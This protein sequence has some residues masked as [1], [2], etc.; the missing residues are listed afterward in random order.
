MQTDYT[1]VTEVPGGKASAE[2]VQ[3]LYSRYHFAAPY[4]QDKDVLEVACGGGQGLGYLVQK[5][6]WAVGG[7]YTQGLLLKAQEH[8]K[9]EIPF[10]RLDAH[11]LPFKNQSFDVVIFFEAI[12]YL[13]R[14]DKFLEECLR[15][16]REKST[17]LICTVNKDWSDFNP[18]PHSV[19]YFSASELYQLLSPRFS[20]VELYGGFLVAANSLRDKIISLIKRVAVTFN[21]MPET[22]KGKELFKRIF[23]GKLISLPREIEE[24]MSEYDCPQ[25]VS[26]EF[27]RPYKVLYAV[28]RND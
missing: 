9:S 11:D 25:P 8:F 20:N 18:S 15:V 13:S 24:G 4:C 21:L 16:L 10:L 14:P 27:T 23:F 19:R 6:K 22:M 7:D 5:A 28:G 26:F 3:R 2:Q 12:Y 1:Q 17:I